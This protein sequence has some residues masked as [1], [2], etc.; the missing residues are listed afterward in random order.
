M[1]QVTDA[2]KHSGDLGGSGKRTREENSRGHNLP[3]LAPRSLFVFVIDFKEQEVWPV[4]S[5][6]LASPQQRRVEGRGEGGAS[7]IHYMRLNPELEG[8]ALW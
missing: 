3:K 6:F 4:S 8:I 2:Q 1:A 5:K 7:T